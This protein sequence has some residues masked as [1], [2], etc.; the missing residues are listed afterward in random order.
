MPFSP[1]FFG[2]E[3]SPSKIEDLAYGYWLIRHAIARGSLQDTRKEPTPRPPARAKLPATSRARIRGWGSE[4][5]PLLFVF[6]F[7]DLCP[8]VLVFGF[9]PWVLVHG[10]WSLL[11]VPWGFSDVWS[12]EMGSI[13]PSSCSWLPRSF[14]SEAGFLG[15]AIGATFLTQLFWLGDLAPLLKWDTEKNRAATYSSLSN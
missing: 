6:C 7:F 10:F 3:G 2:W 15:P 11:W 9:G 14:R 8:W 12:E 13:S 1:N 5:L 4:F